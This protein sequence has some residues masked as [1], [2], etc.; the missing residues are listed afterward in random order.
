MTNGTFI[1]PPSVKLAGLWFPYGYSLTDY[2]RHRNALP[3]T[4]FKTHDTHPEG[5]VSLYSY[6]VSRSFHSRSRVLFSFPSRYSYTIGLDVYLRLEVVASQVQASYPRDP[7][8]E[9]IK[10]LSPSSTGLSPCF[11]AHSRA[12]QVSKVG[13][14]DLPYHTTSLLTYISRFSLS[15][16]VFNRPYSQ[17][18][19]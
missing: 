11:V 8:Q 12:L 5:R 13:S 6:E 16:A 15:C 7:T 19:N 9:Q 17:H 4:L 2:P 3:G 14:K 10:I 18:L 1:P